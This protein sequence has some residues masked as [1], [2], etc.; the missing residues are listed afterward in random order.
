VSEYDSEPVPGLPAYLP[1]GENLLWQGSPAAGAL[2]RRVFHIGLVAAYFAVLMAW[3]LFAG[4]ADGHTLQTIAFDSIPLAITA[5]AGLAIIALLARLI[6][7]TTIYSITSRRIVMRFGVALPMTVN[8]PFTAI[9]SADVLQCSDGTGEVALQVDDLGRLGYLHMWPH[10]R[11]W[12]LRQPQ[13]TLRGLPDAQ[14]VATLLSKALH[15]AAGKPER[16]LRPAAA[17]SPSEGVSAQG[18][19]ASAAA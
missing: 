8:I 10:T 4:I 11:A 19:T 9:K 1:E 5:A 17:P 16:I 14:A 2:A 7:R 18:A 13:P 3:R 6:A 15:A 12:H